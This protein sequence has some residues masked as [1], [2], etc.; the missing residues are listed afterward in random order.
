[1]DV[2]DLG[3]C[4]S[5]VDVVWWIQ[6]VLLCFFAIKTYDGVSPVLEDNIELFFTKCGVFLES[7]VYSEGLF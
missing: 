7:L 2:L 4:S 3:S 6:Y 5:W 1:M